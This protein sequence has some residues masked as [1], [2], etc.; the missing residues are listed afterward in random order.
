MIASGLAGGMPMLTGLLL[1]TA[2]AGAAAPAGV[3]PMPTFRHYGVIDGLPT[4]MVYGVA[5]DRSGYLWIGTH[6]VPA[7]CPPQ[8]SRVFRHAPAHPRPRRPK[9]VPAWLADRG[10]RRGGG[11]E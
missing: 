3:P 10:A 5:Q 7:L 6:A 8:P 9:E 11:G 2:L 4:A 1:I